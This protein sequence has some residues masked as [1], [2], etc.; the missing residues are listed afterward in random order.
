MLEPPN[1]PKFKPTSDA[2][3]GLPR[4]PRK[5]FNLD[6]LI[7]AATDSA[8][9]AT[10]KASKSGHSQ[11]KL[12]L[13]SS[14]SSVGSQKSAKTKRIS[15]SELKSTLWSDSSRGQLPV[16]E[17]RRGGEAT[18]SHGEATSQLKTIVIEQRKLAVAK[19]QY[20]NLAQQKHHQH[21]PSELEAHTKIPRSRSTSVDPPPNYKPNAAQQTSDYSQQKKVPTEQPRPPTNAVSVSST[22]SVA[23]SQAASKAGAAAKPQTE[24]DGKEKDAKHTWKEKA[25]ALTQKRKEAVLTY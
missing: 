14:S 3:D 11:A 23:T 21:A 19:R 12:H 9:P 18:R 2:G 4:S 8:E 10:Q 22:S 15:M 20:A 7:K 16:T 17:I 6:S 5:G 25:I 13:R 24:E 1:I